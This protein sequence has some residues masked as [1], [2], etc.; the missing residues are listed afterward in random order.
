MIEI[1]QTSIF[2]AWLTNLADQKARERVLARLQRAEGGNLGDWKAVG[3]GVSEM[4]IDHG[5]GYRIYFTR[6]GARM[7]V[8]LAGGTKRTQRRDIA[9]AIKIAEELKE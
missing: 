1:V 2:R 9:K 3:S 7:V 5:P 6:E 4:R 8:I